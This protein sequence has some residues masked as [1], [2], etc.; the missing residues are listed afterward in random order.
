MV[1]RA[2]FAFAAALVLLPHEPDTGLLPQGPQTAVGSYIVRAETLLKTRFVEA[3]EN[4]HRQKAGS[5][6][7]RPDESPV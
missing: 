3:V 6:G 1:L 4:L 7:G 5:L 2:I